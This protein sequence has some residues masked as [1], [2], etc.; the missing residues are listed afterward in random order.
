MIK[1]FGKV[2]YHWQPEL[3]WSIIY[4]SIT[5]I[6]I[7]IAMSLFY[8]RA[9]VPRTGLTFIAIFMIFVGL[10]FHRYFVIGEDN[11]LW[12]ISLNFLKPL[13]V[14]IASIKRIEVTRTTLALIFTNGKSRLFYMRKWPKKY[15]LDDLALNPAFKGEVELLDHSDSLDYFKLYQ[16][17]KKEKPSLRNQ[18]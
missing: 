5:F 17:D 7:F 4:W 16:N 2:R 12:I 8:E 10:G 14:D 6:P 3:S 9:S 11:K 15:F 1:I 13:K 18:S